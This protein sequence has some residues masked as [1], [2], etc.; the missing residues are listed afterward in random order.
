MSTAHTETQAPAPELDARSR[1][2][3][4]WA[5]RLASLFALAPLGVWTVIHLWDNLAAFDGAE[6][7]QKSV[8][9]YATPVGVIAVSAL[10]LVPLAWHGGWG[11]ERVFAEKPNWPRYGYFANL[12]YVLQ[13]LSAIGILAFLVAHVWLAF[14]EPRLVEHRPEP[15]ADIAH[16]MHFH[17]P[18]LA[19]YVL[20]VLGVAYH[21]ANGTQ[22]F[23]MSWGVVGT[24]RAL[25][26]WTVWTFAFFL[27]LLAMGW[28]S[29]WALWSAG[30]KVQLDENGKPIPTEAAPAPTA[31]TTP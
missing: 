27:V 6:A 2:A 22:T 7:W 30:A 15:F 8:T 19:V 23:L 4:F 20:G 14:I 11:V 1:R 5:N 24:R 28:A 29:V 13:R 16:E 21:L 25:K 26:K 31:T 10:V 3:S 9:G 17:G 18:T 12:R